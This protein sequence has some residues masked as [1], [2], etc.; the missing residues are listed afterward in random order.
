MTINVSSKLTPFV[1]APLLDNS[2]AL[3]PDANYRLSVVRWKTPKDQKENAS[4]KARPAICVAVPKV[5][6]SVQP[7]ALNAAMQ[8]ALNE[9]Q[10]NVI[11]SALNAAIEENTAINLVGATIDKNTLTA[12][13]I[14]SWSREQSVS[15]R[16]SKEAIGAWFDSKLSDELGIKIA[17]TN[18]TIDADKLE[19]AVRQHREILMQLASPRA[20]MPE[21]LASQLQRAVNLVPGSDKVKETLNAKLAGF[22][23]PTEISL[24]LGL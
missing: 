4:F 21:K 20:A 12:D 17:E 2:E 14:A 7:E 13:G 3:L 22:L 1:V 24:E 9:L 11:R 18:P 5:V 16:L 15:G 10:D 23:K 6:L 19:K 8:D